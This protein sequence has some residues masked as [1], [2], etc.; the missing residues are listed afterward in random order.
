MSRGVTFRH[1]SSEKLSHFRAIN[2]FT[3]LFGELFCDLKITFA[4]ITNFYIR[5]LTEFALLVCLDPQLAKTAAQ[6]GRQR[7]TIYAEA[8]DRFADFLVEI[9]VAAG[10]VTEEE[11]KRAKDAGILSNESMAIALL[12]Q[13]PDLTVKQ[14]A[15]RLD[16]HEKRPYQW[17]RFMNLFRSIRAADPPPHGSVDPD[18][19]LE[20]WE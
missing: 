3:E 12:M 5:F 7:G 18:G 17:I 20:A 19:N 10:A 15:D 8:I 16:V 14:V 9:E 1:K 6:D 2:F 11:K 4:C 13:Q